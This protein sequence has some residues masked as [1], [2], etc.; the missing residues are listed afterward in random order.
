MAYDGRTTQ[1]DG[2]GANADVGA[3]LAL[4]GRIEPHTVVTPPMVFA[5]LLAE[6]VEEMRGKGIDKP[7]VVSLAGDVEVEAASE[8]LFD[9]KV[10][11]YPYSTE[12]P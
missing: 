7:V 8:Y 12:I 10:P 2:F 3:P 5:R 6:I 9:Y 1:L 4:A 11:A